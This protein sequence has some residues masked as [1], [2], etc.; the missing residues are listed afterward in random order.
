MG[1]KKVQEPEEKLYYLSYTSHGGSYW[2]SGEQWGDWKE[3]HGTVRLEYLSSESGRG[4]LVATHKNMDLE[5]GKTY[6]LVWVT[7][8]SGDSFGH[9]TGNPEFIMVFDNINDAERLRNEIEIQY[10]TTKLGEYDK[11]SLDFDGLPIYCGAWLGY[12]DSLEGVH[13]DTVVYGG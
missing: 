3:D 11:W 5:L 8:S 10:R 9:S 4:I 2:H 7:Y 12:F 13:I 6:F 1:K